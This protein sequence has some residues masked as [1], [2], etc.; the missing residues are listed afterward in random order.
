MHSSKKGFV[1]VVAILYFVMGFSTYWQT[2]RL[3][4]QIA[5]LRNN[6]KDI[7]FQMKELEDEI[8]ELEDEVDDL[9]NKYD[10]LHNSF[11]NLSSR[12]SSLEIALEEKDEQTIDIFEGE[13]EIL[14]ALIEAEAGNQDFI[15]KCL[16]ADVVINR[17]DSDIFPDSIKDVILEAHYRKR[18]KVMCYQFSTV[19]YG[20]YQK[21]LA[22]GD[23]SAE[24]Y[25]AAKQEYESERIDA[26]ILYFTAGGF[27][28]YCI[29]AY[30]YGDH[31]FGY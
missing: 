14:A 1:T 3:E 20:T 4:E 5:N 11:S 26:D 13:I 22:L 16:V 10:N 17:R 9:S 23:I 19:K 6:M 2:K 24:S 25:V 7:D 28:D 29:P 15:G 21:I 12:V 27:N 18:D 31:Y 30:V 8:R